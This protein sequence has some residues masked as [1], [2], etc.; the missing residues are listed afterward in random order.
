[1]TVVHSAESTAPPE[2]AWKLLAEPRCWSRWAPHVRGA[3]GLGDPEVEEGARGSVLLPGG[4]PV[5]AEIL[6]VDAGRS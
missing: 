2:V 6:T 1:M 3:R 4:L 5:A